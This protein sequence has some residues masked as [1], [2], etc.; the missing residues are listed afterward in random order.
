MSWTAVIIGG[1]TVLGG[2]LSAQGAKKAAGAAAAGSDAAIAEQRRQF[3]IIRGDTADYRAIGNQALNALGSVYGYQPAAQYFGPDPYAGNAYGGPQFDDSNFFTTGAGAIL[4]PA[5][6]TS[7]LG[8]AGKFLDPVGSFIGGLFG[9]K[10]GDEK[11]NIKAFLEAF[12]VRDLGNG[13]LMLPDGTQLPES[14][15]Q[16]L[17]GTWYGATF[18]PDGNQE[19][20]QQQYQTALNSIKSLPVNA[21]RANV[22]Q[23]GGGLTS[24]G[25]QQGFPGP[26][27]VDQ[28]GNIVGGAPNYRNFFASPDYQ[29]RLGEG[30]NAVQNS[31]AAQGGLYSGNALRGI[32][33]YGQGLAAGEF[34]NWFN[35][36]AALAGIGQTATAQN[37][38]AGLMTGANVGNALIASGN[39]RA[40]GIAGQ[41]NAI[42][43]G[44]SGLAQGVG[45]WNANRGGVSPGW[46]SGANLNNAWF[47]G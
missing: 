23:A 33:E 27:T 2:A 43:A 22:G 28:Q 1:A 21:S 26:V 10:H 40:S 9:N 12:P 29:F 36:Q 14:Q 35:R 34:G 18:A 44:L 8:G 32:T 15:L 45:Y 16:H 20:W 42:G 5:T 13:M 31:A 19:G 30:L 24:E 17:A 38:Q 11:R 39:A 4:N 25:V 3:D 47:G 6:V 46:G 41:Y 37:A 7:M